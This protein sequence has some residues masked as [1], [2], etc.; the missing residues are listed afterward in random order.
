MIEQK[1]V[2]VAVRDGIKIA[3]RIYRPDGAGPFPTLFVAS[4]YRYDNNDLPAYPLFL[5][6]EREDQSR[7]GT[8]VWGL[9]RAD[10]KYFAPSTSTFMINYRVRNMDR[11]LA[12]LKAQG[13]QVDGKIDLEPGQIVM[14]LDVPFLLKPFKKQAIEIVE[15][16]IQKWI[17]KAKSGEI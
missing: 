11:M 12:Q 5:W 15:G 9:F 16:Q 7:V 4:P 1:D 10:T 13:V 2:Q 8:T 14:D 6:R 17:Q 3:L